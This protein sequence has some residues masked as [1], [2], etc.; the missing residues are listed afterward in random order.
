[1]KPDLKHNE[2]PVSTLGKIG[3]YLSIG[4]ELALFLLVFIF[5]GRYLDRMYGTEP[6]LMIAGAALGFVGG[7]YSLFRTLSR[8]NRSEKGKGPG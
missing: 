4:L 1:V 8:L 5:I 7:F 6:W 3:P 2:G